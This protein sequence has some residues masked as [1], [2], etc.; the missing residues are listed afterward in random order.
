M[1]VEQAPPKSQ[2]SSPTL[3]DFTLED[4]YT[5]ASGT[6]IMSGIQ[7]L[8]RLPMDQHRADNLRGLHTASLITGYRGSPLGALDFVLER[9]P[10]LLNEHHIRFI[11]A[12]NEELAATAIMGSQ[13]VNLLPGPKYDGVCGI[14]YGKGP[15]VDR[16]GDAFKHANLTGVG[17]HGGVLAL[18]GDDP[19][20]KSSTIPSHSEV[21]LYDALMPILYP[22]SAQE[23]LDLGLLGFALSRFSGLWV[24]F[25]IVTDVADEY[26]SVEVGF[27]RVNSVQPEFKLNGQRWRPRQNPDLIS[28]YSLQQEQEIH[29]ARLDAA[30]AFARANRINEIALPTADAWLGIIAAGKTWYDLRAA[31]LEAGLDDA[32]L[33][34]A[35]IR[36][37]KLGMIF[38]LEPEI[39]REFAAGL[40]EILVI[41][42]KRAFIEVF[43]K[44]ALYGSGH[45]PL[46]IGKKDEAGNKLV[47]A[48]NEL[49]ADEILRVLA[50]RLKGRVDAPLLERRLREINRAPALGTI[51]IASRSPY[52]CSGCP[53]NRSTK[54]PEGSMAAAGI[55]CHTLAIL[56]DRNTAGVTQMGGEGANWVGAETFTDIDHIFQNIGDGTFAHS[57]SLSIRQATAA[58]ANMTFKILYN[59]AVA[60][61][62]GQAADGLMPVPELTHLLYAEGVKKTIV[63]SADPEIYSPD[64]SW[65][66]GSE[67]WE[68]DRMEEAQ[69]L[70]RDTPGV[71]ALVYDQECAA[72]LRRK[73][74]R[75]YAPDP[76]LRIVINEAVCEGCGDCGS[77]SNCLSVQ[78]VETEFG[79]KT[80]IHQSSCN[81]DY[82]CLEGNCPAFMSVIPDESRADTA[83]PSFRVERDIAEPQRRVNGNANILFMGIGGTGVVTSNQVLGTA[84]ALDGFHVRS[85]DQ[86]GLSQKGGPVVSNLKITS[87][88]LD[89]APKIGAAAADAFL[90]FDAL[91]A[92]ESKNL[93]RAHPQRSIAIVSN[94]QV[95][96]GAMVRDT[97]VEYPEADHVLE[98]INRQ[99]LAGDNVFFD[100]IGLAEALFHD[101]M[102]ANMIVIGAAYQAGTLP[103]SAAAIE[104]AIELNGVKVEDNQHA[105]RAGRLAVAEPTWLESLKIE[106]AGAVE[107][108]AAPSAA[109]RQLIDSVGASGE[110]KRLLEIRAPE[111][112]A[113][114]NEAYARRYIADVKR[115]YEA[116]QAAIPASTELSEAFARYL[117][118]LMAYKDE[119]EVARLS[120]KPEMR[121]ALAEQFGARA[122]L[123]YH[124][125]PPILKA[126]GLKGKIRFG[127]SFDLVYRALHKLRFLRGTRLD[128]FGYDRV[129]RVERDLIA[130]YR[131]LV[132]A[133][134]EDLSAENQTRAVALAKLPDMIRGYDE[135]KLGNVE[136]FWEAV[137]ELGFDAP[138]E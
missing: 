61:T 8:A 127:R 115:V 79:R 123:H 81:K 119:Y 22:G 106:R 21:A 128:L 51:P 77:V 10:R 100:A 88:P 2:T 107:T 104:R 14:W 60:M 121:A 35:G 91:T 101:H 84:A 125:Q 134:L 120:L 18:A 129:R 41:E 66:P 48:D 86:T 57:G 4:R 114:Q 43:C 13:T 42:E 103:M 54:V 99:T 78:P 11:P 71:T 5:A 111:L 133:A 109:A 124:L 112:I 52:F 33:E 16:S 138:G 118:K 76:A 75:G 38:P 58:G 17:E 92:T 70:L 50:R 12:V 37:L 30:L 23:I 24:G 49:D 74:R 72:N 108:V 132:F 90:V 56:M 34:R 67:V 31:M 9:I 117:F 137:R 1:L 3:A 126:L 82:T 130:Q 28:P 94:S 44:E 26:S 105:F 64:A 80:Q 59:S 46:V 45:E 65:A 47:K 98:L 19:S 131:R 39:L 68:R 7:A 122:K 116:E 36:L 63:V 93:I 102:M 73:R 83:K 15:G 27:D 69:L 29:D 6:V 97:T 40:D 136:R 85:L 110:L 32:A 55:G 96:T 135:V 62:G 95:P 89:I 87:E 25:K 113:Y 53:H 20:C